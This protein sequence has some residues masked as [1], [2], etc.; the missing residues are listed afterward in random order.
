MMNDQI[1]KVEWRGEKAEV[2]FPLSFALDEETR[3]DI[4][5]LFDFFFRFTWKFSLTPNPA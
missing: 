5:N 1:E 3:F 2:D 4:V